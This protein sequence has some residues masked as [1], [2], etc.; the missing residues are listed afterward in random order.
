ML[1]FIRVV[2][3]SAL[4]ASE[5]LRRPWRAELSCALRRLFR[6]YIDGED[7]CKGFAQGF[8]AC[9]RGVEQGFGSASGC[10]GRVSGTLRVCR[11]TC[12]TARPP[13]GL[14][15]GCRLAALFGIAHASHVCGCKVLHIVIE[16]KHCAVP[17]LTST[18]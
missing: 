17:P 4:L 1:G 7:M 18:W 15:R 8:N 2:R 3:V 12:T 16:T 14:P 5:K 11:P 13:G 6:R 10:G 9:R